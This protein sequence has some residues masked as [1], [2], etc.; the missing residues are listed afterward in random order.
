MFSFLGL[1]FFS[2]RVLGQ[3]KA[4]H[5]TSNNND[6]T[7]T[8][9]TTQQHQPQQQEQ[10]HQQPPTTKQQTHNTTNYQQT[11]HNRGR[12]ESLRPKP[13]EEQKFANMENRH[14]FDLDKILNIPRHLQ[15]C[16][17]DCSILLFVDNLLL[18]YN[19]FYVFLS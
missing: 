16:F 3:P 15:K 8:T 13:C 19:V 14:R 17:P 4:A 12:K 9:T 11:T 5:K 10:Q 1:L 2:W 6:K 7:T 18:S